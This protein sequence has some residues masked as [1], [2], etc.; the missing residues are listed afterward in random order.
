MAT[1]GLRFSIHPFILFA[2]IIIFPLHFFACPVF[3][4]RRPISDVNAKELGGDNVVPT[5][6]NHFNILVKYLQ[7]E[8]RTIIS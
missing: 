8:K 1:N 2:I 7:Y 6:L 4:L 3:E 5:K